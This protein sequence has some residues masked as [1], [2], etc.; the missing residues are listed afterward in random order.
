MALATASAVILA[1]IVAAKPADAATSLS[2]EAEKMRGSGKVFR[3]RTASNNKAKVFYRNRA[4]AT[5][6]SGSLRSIAVRARGDQC[7]GAPRMK[8][9]VDGK[10]VMVRSVKNQKKWRYY[11][12]RINIPRGRHIVKVGF[13]NDRRT[14]KCDRN[15]R[16]DKIRVGKVALRTKANTDPFEGEKLYVDPNSKAKKQADQWRSSRPED[17]A[18]MDKI[19]ARPTASWFGGWNSDIRASVNGYVTTVRNAGALPIYGGL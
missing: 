3:D 6:V 1:L 7:G 9:M 12:K 13:I 19:A 15:L 2:V 14:R 18:Q 8:V 5:R 10:R 16:V 17:A 4:A 11:E